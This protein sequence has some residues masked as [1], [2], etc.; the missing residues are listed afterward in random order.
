MSGVLY[1]VGSMFGIAVTSAPEGSTYEMLIGGVCELPKGTGVGTGFSA[2][3]AVYHDSSTSTM[4]NDSSGNT[5][6][7][8]AV[9]D[10]ND[11]AGKVVVRL[12]TSF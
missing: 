7:G 6:V 9:L 8:V 1:E 3:D 10:A 11:D 4:T 2:G 5:K 12:N